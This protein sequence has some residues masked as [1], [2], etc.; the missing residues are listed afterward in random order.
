MIAERIAQGLPFAAELLR[1]RAKIA[2]LSA[3]LCTGFAG[4]ARAPT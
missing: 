3:A 4:S 2:G 1:H